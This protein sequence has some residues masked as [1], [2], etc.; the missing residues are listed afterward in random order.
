MSH[1]GLRDLLAHVQVP[2]QAPL[3][4]IIRPN[5]EPVTIQLLADDFIDWV[6]V[7]PK[8]HLTAGD[9]LVRL[10]PGRLRARLTFVKN[11]L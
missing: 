3:S 5:A 7:S 10:D 6:T 1:W 11:R 8:D 9:V 2:G 4:G